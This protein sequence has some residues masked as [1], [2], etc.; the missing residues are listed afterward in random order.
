MEPEKALNCHG[1]VEKEKQSCGHHNAGFQGVLQS[2]DH[3]DSMV[4]AQKQTHRPMEQK[5]SPEMDP[6]LYGQLIFDKAGKNIKWKKDSLF[7]KWC[8][9]NWTVTYRRMKVFLNNFLLC[10]VSLHTVHH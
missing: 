6:Q 10:Y 3:K 2:C 9:E 5:E 7:K 4:L 1:S 8:W